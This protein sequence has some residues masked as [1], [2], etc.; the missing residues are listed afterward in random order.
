MSL[1]LA[2]EHIDYLLTIL[3]IGVIAGYLGYMIGNQRD[4]KQTKVVL[5]GGDRPSRASEITKLVCSGGWGEV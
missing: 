1:L 3:A 4:K 5:R 2:V